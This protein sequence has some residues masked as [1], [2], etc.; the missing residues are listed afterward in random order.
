M[1]PSPGSASCYCVT[2][3][4][5]FNCLGLLFWKME[6]LL[7]GATVRHKAVDTYKELRTGP[8]H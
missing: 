1:D 4:K 5:L 8:G 3:N 2:L 7:A 6:P